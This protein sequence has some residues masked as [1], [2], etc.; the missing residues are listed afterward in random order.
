MLKVLSGENP[1]S[2]TIGDVRFMVIGSD[3]PTTKLRGKSKGGG[4]SVSKTGQA[5]VV[6][7]WMEPV[8]VASCNKVVEHLAEYLLGVNY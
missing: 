4:C 2:F 5:L 7:I 1:G 8:P 6:G 3:E